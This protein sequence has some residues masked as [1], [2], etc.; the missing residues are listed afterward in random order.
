MQLVGVAGAHE[1]GVEPVVGSQD[2]AE[3]NDR[4]PAGLVEQPN[5]GR[6]EVVSRGTDRC[7]GGKCRFHD[8]VD[9]EKAY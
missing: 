8:L 9:W 1:R 7:E 6:V 3:T 2:S 5:K 4:R